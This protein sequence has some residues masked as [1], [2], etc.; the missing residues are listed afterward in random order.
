M[1]PVDIPFRRVEHHM[2]TAV[3]LGGCGI[4]EAAAD[5]F[6]GRVAELEALLSRFRP[7]SQISRLARGEVVLDD[8]DPLV[9]QVMAG[10]VALRGLTNGAFEHEPRRR[11]GHEGDLALDVNAYAKGWIIEEASTVLQMTAGEWFVNAGGDV[12][13]GPRAGG[14]TWRVGVQHPADRTAVLGA[15]EVWRGA[16]ATSGHYERGDHM[17]GAS[18]G[19]GLVSVTVVGPDLGWAD[20]LATA[21]FASGESAPSWWPD[22]EPTYGLLTLDDDQR[23]RWLPP[24]EGSDIEWTFPPGSD[25]VL[26]AFQQ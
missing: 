5:A 9:R 22:V 15:F 14:T 8:V 3:T 26:T 20:G 6:F 7:H 2:S 23:L 24:R 13:A 10:C 12:V 16:V 4:A 1:S 18:E 25:V 11:S 21:V 17:R 19:P